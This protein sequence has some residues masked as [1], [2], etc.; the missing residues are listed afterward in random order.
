MKCRDCEYA[1]LR[2]CKTVGGQPYSEVIC[3]VN[4]RKVHGGLLN[5]GCDDVKQGFW[6][7]GV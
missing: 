6:W 7:R 2:Q 4:G 5:G 1:Q 3:A